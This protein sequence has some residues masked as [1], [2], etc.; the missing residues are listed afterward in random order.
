MMLRSRSLFLAL[1]LLAVAAACQRQEMSLSQ[2]DKD[3]IKAQVEKYRQAALAADWDAWGSTLANDVIVSPAHMAPMTGRAAAVAWVRTFP[4]LTNF[5]VNFDEIDGRGDLA[6]T[7]GT[8]TLEMALAD[9]SPA[10]EHGTFLEIHRRQADGTWP[11]TRLA[12]HS[13]DPLAAAAPASQP[14]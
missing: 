10:T 6:Y 14:R 1:S 13:T 12:F 8:Y 7:R 2:A 5:T 9:G 11:Y 3:G 4:K